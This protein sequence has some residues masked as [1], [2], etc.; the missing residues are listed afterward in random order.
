MKSESESE[1]ESEGEKICDTPIYLMLPKWT[2]G[3]VKSDSSTIGEDGRANTQGARGGNYKSTKV[4]KL[5]RAKYY[6]KCKMK[7]KI[8]SMISGVGRPL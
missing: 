4:H 7:Y 3:D 6:L 2:E 1:S 5:K 8:D